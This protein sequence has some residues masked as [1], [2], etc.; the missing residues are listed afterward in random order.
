MY[1]PNSFLDNDKIVLEG[2]IQT[3]DDISD[4]KFKLYLEYVDDDGLENSIY[5]EVHRG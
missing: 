2:S 4:T 3:I 1:F 5:Y